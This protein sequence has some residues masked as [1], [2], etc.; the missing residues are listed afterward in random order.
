M[1]VSNQITSYT[2]NNELDLDKIIDNYT[3]YIK[4]IIYNMADSLNYE[5]KE[6][7]LADTFFVLWKN[8]KKEILNLDSY[9]AGITKNLIKEKFRKRSITYDLSEF[10]NS[11]GN[12]DIDIFSTERAFIEELKDTFKISDSI[13]LEI[14]NMFYFYSISTKNIAK[15]LNISEINVRSKLFRMRKKIKKILDKKEKSYE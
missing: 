11:V 4:S 14:L 6:E 3:P 2:K 5:D 7:I 10:E 9:L 1:K 8:R 13:D 12:N 15:R